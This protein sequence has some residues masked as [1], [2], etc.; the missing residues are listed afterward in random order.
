M[1]IDELQARN[2]HTYENGH[3]YYG[4]KFEYPFPDDK[5]AQDTHSGIERLWR[6]LLDWKVFV[7]PLPSPLGKNPQGAGLR[8][9]E[10]RLGG[11]LLPERASQGLCHLNGPDIYADLPGTM[12]LGG[13]L[14]DWEGFYDNAFK[15]L[16]PGG[17][18]E[19]KEQ[20]IRLCSDDGGVPDAVRQWQELLE[21]A[22]EKFGKRINVARKQREWMERAGFAEVKEEAFK[23][24][25]GQWSEGLKWKEI[26]MTYS[27]QLLKSLDVYSL[28][29]FTHTLGWSEEDTDALLGRVREQLKQ[30]DLRLYSYFHVVVGQKPTTAERWR[31]RVQQPS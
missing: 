13:L 17:W 25:L 14:T 23:V 19:V 6:E 28:R 18:L 22:A 20:D 12:S 15:H 11:E 8:Y 29:L 1:Q 30:E 3:R 2:N 7:A 9:A 27:Y 10:C 5:D 26:G 31:G 21:E 4:F 24:P 16:V